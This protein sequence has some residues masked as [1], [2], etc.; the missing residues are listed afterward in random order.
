MNKVLLTGATGYLGSKLTAKLLQQGYRV[1]CPVL[2]DTHLAYLIPYVEQVEIFVIDYTTL[3][4]TIMTFLPD[5]VIHTACR[6]DREGISLSELTEANLAFPLKVLNAIGNLPYKA[7]W[8][9]ANTALMSIINGYTLSKF[10]FAEWGRYC[11][12][13]KKV[14][15]LNILIEHF[16]GEGDSG[17]K[18]LPYLINKMKK[19]EPIDL[20]DGTQHRDFIYVDDVILT[21]ENICQWL[22]YKCSIG[23]TFYKCIFINRN[24]I[25]K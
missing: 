17:S 9:N 11:S 14:D 8:I 3:N 2:T 20:T 13:Q 1:L 21:S 7:L 24:K 15:F 16:Y 12:K 5:I 23:F 4:D 19:N 25:I 22:S 18:F 6:Y 10:Q